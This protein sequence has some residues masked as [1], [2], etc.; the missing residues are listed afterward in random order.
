MAGDDLAVLGEV[1]ATSARVVL[2]EAMQ[3]SRDA[4]QILG[5][6][7][8][9]EDGL[10]RSPTEV[11]GIVLHEAAHALA[12]QRRIAD[13]SRQGRYH[14]RRFRTI[15]EELG[16]EVRQDP[17][18]GWCSTSVSATIALRYGEAP[19]VLGRALSGVPDRVPFNGSSSTVTTCGCDARFQ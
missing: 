13:T 15:A 9:T 5:E 2:Q 10:A 18:F 3:L 4:S 12:S 7:M 14:N 11:L 19:T 17:P 16:L 8:L 1:L 6:V